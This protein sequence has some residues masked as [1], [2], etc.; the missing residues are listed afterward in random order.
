[1]KALLSARAG[2]FLSGNSPRDE[3]YGHAGGRCPIARW[4]HA[5]WMISPDNGRA[6][7][8]VSLERHPIVVGAVPIPTIPV[9]QGV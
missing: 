1:M 2:K 5:L 6:C 8:W 3:F 7:F 9:E 4:P